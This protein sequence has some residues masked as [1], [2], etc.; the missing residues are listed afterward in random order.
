MFF[1]MQSYSLK[2]LFINNFLTKS[3]Q[4]KN[5]ILFFYVGEFHK[6]LQL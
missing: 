2:N 6:G 5:W 4:T 1:I 3:V